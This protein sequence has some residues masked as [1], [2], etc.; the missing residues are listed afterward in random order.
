VTRHPGGRVAAIEGPGGTRLVTLRPRDRADGVIEEIHRHVPPPAFAAALACA[1]T[2]GRS[3][4][5]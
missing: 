4:E 1:R 5:A 2:L 3:L